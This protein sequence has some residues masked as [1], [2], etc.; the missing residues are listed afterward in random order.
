MTLEAQVVEKTVE[1]N[2]TELRSYLFVLLLL[3]FWK[4]WLIAS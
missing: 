1:V 3:S 2:K 4:S